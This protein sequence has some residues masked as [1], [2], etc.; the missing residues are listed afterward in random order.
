MDN[1]YKEL[2]KKKGVTQKD[3][4]EQTGVSIRTLNRYENGK[5][6]GDH[7]VVS[8]LADYYGVS[9]DLLYGKI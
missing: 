2:R 4:A 5:V 8:I 3:C 9:M 6:E 7:K 1:I